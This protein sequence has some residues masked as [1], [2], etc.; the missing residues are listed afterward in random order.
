MFVIDIRDFLIPEQLKTGAFQ[1][2]L[3]R[4][5]ARWW[6]GKKWTTRWHMRAGP[7]S[8]P[9]PTYTPCRMVTSRTLSNVLENS[10]M[11]CCF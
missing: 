6:W 2:K 5:L 10:R 11:F 8:T 1:G 9:T 3:A 4:P 7:P